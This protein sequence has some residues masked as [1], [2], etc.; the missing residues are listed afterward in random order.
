MSDEAP[1]P[2][3]GSSNG[4]GT[5]WPEVV[6]AGGLMLL[7]LLV[8]TDSIRVG[9]G[10]GDEGP[11]SG[12]FPFYIGLLLLLS[13]GTV[14]V[15]TL[16]RWRKADAVFVEREQLGMVFAVLVPMVVYVGGIALAGIYAAS[17]VLIAYFM[18]RHGKFGWSWTVGVS[19][20]VPLVF[21]LVFER[22]FL[23]PLPKGPIERLLGL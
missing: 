6:V 10:W 2:G 16:L 19:V 22:W 21:F 17:L 18:R 15:T 1:D 23:V 3:R 8:I 5:R 13:S 14:L 4:L 11:R 12:Y 9:T 20:G 7:A